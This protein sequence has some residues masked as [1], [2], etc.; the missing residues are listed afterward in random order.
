M[1]VIAALKF[2]EGQK[3]V[4]HNKVWRLIEYHRYQDI[5]NR[6]APYC[7]IIAQWRAHLAHLN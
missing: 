1:T 6:H 7:H 4:C 3:R 5:L 2:K